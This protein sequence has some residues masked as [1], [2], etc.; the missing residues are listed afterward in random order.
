MG[1][2]LGDDKVVAFIV[3]FTWSQSEAT[4]ATTI[5]SLSL[6]ILFEPR[7]MIFSIFINL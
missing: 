7:W 6:A 5:S 4:F 1:F 2:H 3:V